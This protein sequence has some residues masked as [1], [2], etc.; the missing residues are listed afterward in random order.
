[1]RQERNGVYGTGKV[2]GRN[3]RAQDG[4]RDTS[5]M[6]NES[7]SEEVVGQDAKDSSG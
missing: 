7:P 4:A 6:E 5:R 3:R 1:M 2:S